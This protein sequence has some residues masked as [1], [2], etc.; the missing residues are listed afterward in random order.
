MGS[1]TSKQQQQAH[2]RLNEVDEKFFARLD[3]PNSVESR[4]R[5]WNTNLQNN[6]RSLSG[7]EVN[8]LDGNPSLLP[9]QP[10]TLSS[11]EGEPSPPTQDGADAQSPT[12]AFTG[13]RADASIKAQY[14][15]SSQF[16]TPT[17][18][19]MLRPAIKTSSHEQVSGWQSERQG[20]ALQLRLAKHRFL[21][22]AE[23][24]QSSPNGS[25]VSPVSLD[26][27]LRMIPSSQDSG[28]TDIDHPI[29][30][31]SPLSTRTKTIRGKD[32]SIQNED[33]P[34]LNFDAA[35]GMIWKEISR[36]HKVTAI[37]MSR[38]TDV[39]H[40]LQ[41]YP[42]MMAMGD[43]QGNIVLTQIIDELVA[44]AS[45][46]GQSSWP[47]T[48]LDLL[49]SEALKYSIDERVRSLDFA[50]GGYLAVGGDG[51]SAL[52]LEIIL[53]GSNQRLKDLVPI[54]KVERVD[55][56]Y[57]VRFSP[58]NRYLAVGGFDGMV[59][60]I[61][62]EEVWK[63]NKTEIGSNG[64]D[65][66]SLSEIMRSSLIE[67]DSSGLVYS[68]DWSPAGEYL[69]VAGSDKSC[70]IYETKGFD[71]VHETACRSTAIQAVQWNQN[72]TFLAIGDREVVIIEGKPPFNI[73]CEISH[74]PN[75]STMTHFRS[76]ITSL[77][78]SPSGSYLAIG[79][80]DGICLVIETK[81]Y[82]LV[83][84]VH[85]T[86][87]IC[88]LAWGQQRNLTGD[89]RRYLALSD[90]DCNVALVKAGAE[91]K[92]YE[93]FDDHSSVASSSQFSAAS[94]WI[95]RED[96]FRDLDEAEPDM[97]PADFKAQA[98]NVTALA[99]SK[100]GKSKVSSYLA[101]ACDDC[102]LTIMTTRDWKPVFVSPLRAH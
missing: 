45:P 7:I 80:V 41:T 76:R 51:C 84:E 36:D 77:C 29:N 28:L 10:W 89:M 8:T 21:Q 31:W 72:G 101:F 46:G 79:G 54:Y 25:P 53:D 42:L 18:S 9:A 63:T 78:W 75:E 81:G 40:S 61:P 24:R 94:E 27:T 3:T 91:A 96:T 49:P 38:T 64:E 86:D 58:D 43:E 37:A 82:A 100:S 97:L 87:S 17:S 34:R 60:L 19:S 30:D 12:F 14:I 73:H 67:L 16:S 15:S 56:I 35:Q 20:H 65:D 47:D 2:E 13:T 90:E 85:R 102:S 11:S 95:L 55:R 26:S 92:G 98:S 71:L 66:D 62:M 68:L 4:R 5:W 88:A 39:A 70:S 33:G 57:A 50:N 48:Q 59:A 52:I 99:F 74:T 69:A 32:A 93:T 6:G 1:C 83:H 23:T 44:A 22:M